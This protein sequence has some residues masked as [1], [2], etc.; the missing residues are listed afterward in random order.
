M[1]A[2]KDKLSSLKDA[3]GS[4]FN[5]IYRKYHSHRK[6]CRGIFIGLALLFILAGLI[7]GSYQSVD[8]LSQGVPIN[9]SEGV[10]KD[11]Q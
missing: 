3:V 10:I 8:S 11:A 1:Q 6:K 7:L 4:I 5:V 9:Y 2:I